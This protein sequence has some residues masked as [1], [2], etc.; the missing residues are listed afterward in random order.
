MRLPMVNS[1]TPNVVEQNL[2]PNLQVPPPNFQIP[3]IQIP[4]VQQEIVQLNYQLLSAT[5]IAITNVSLFPGL[6]VVVNRDNPDPFG[7]WLAEFELIL[8]MA[9]FMDAQKKGWLVQ[10]MVKNARYEIHSIPNLPALSY[11]EGWID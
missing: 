6:E 9:H 10:K 7:D 3:Q 8:S 4:P 2:Q 5:I 1:V 11:G